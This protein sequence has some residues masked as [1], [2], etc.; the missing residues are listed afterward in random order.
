MNALISL[1]K[2]DKNKSKKEPSKLPVSDSEKDVLSSHTENV[3]ETEATMEITKIEVTIESPQ[4][5]ENTKVNKNEDS[6]SDE[7]SSGESYEDAVSPRQKLESELILGGTG[8]N[9][10]ADIP[11]PPTPPTPVKI[12]LPENK[13]SD[14]EDSSF[15]SDELPYNNIINN[16]KSE[17]LEVPKGET[18]DWDTLIKTFKTSQSHFD[19]YD[20]TYNPKDWN[21]EKGKQ[22]LYDSSS[23]EYIESKKRKLNSETCN[24][25]VTKK[26]IEKIVDELSDDWNQ[27]STES[28][29]LESYTEEGSMPSLES[30]TEEESMPSLE[31]Y[32]EEELVS[33]ESFNVDQKSIV[34][35]YALEDDYLTNTGK[36]ELYIGPMYSGKSTTILLKLARMADMDFNV[37]YINHSDDVRE[38]ESQDQAVTTHNSQFKSISEKIHYVKSSELRSVNVDDF[39]YIGIDEG[40]FYSD[41]YDTVIAWI[42]A[43]GKN[44]MIAS[45]D[46]DFYRR[47]FGQVL[48]LIPHADKVKKLTAFCDVCKNNTRKSEPEPAPFTGRLSKDKDP[49]LVGGRNIYMAMCRS[50]HDIHLQKTA[51]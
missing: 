14:S 26:D 4:M 42:T 29:S 10:I 32:T 13:E 24:K 30:Y 44:V 17:S 2:K 15:N 20:F 6:W 46:G 51:L 39:D 47:T 28:M 43:Y 3:V 12:K 45:L 23:E 7:W 41:L 1:F 35:E 38:T 27:E 48:D 19:T 16:V 21:I 36:L 34:C 40:Q 37:I 18:I 49:K 5:I 11:T 31:S 8:P 9:V 22:E 25:N 33:V 50:C